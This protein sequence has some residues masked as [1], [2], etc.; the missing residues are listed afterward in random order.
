MMSEPVSAPVVTFAEL[1]FLLRACPD[2]ADLVRATLR[3]APGSVGES[4]VAAGLAS[5]LARNLLYR[6]EDGTTTRAPEIGF[7]VDCLTA[8]TI[9]V[10]ALGWLGRWQVMAHVFGRPERRVALYPH[11]HGRFAVVALDPAEPVGVVLDRFLDRCVAA[12][13]ET[14]T[15]ARSGRNAV[16]LLSVAVDASGGWW[17]SD[18]VDAPDRAVRVDRSAVLRRLAELFDPALAAS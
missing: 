13:G 7:L 14:A 6:A 3:L 9:A 16:P 8:P 4:V 17:L 15:L 2:G 1:S 10:S 11:G 12:G 18:S 5:L